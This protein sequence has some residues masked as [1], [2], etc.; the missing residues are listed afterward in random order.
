MVVEFGEQSVSLWFA[1]R[2]I[3]SSCMTKAS[4][5]CPLR[6]R[7]W[8]ET[9]LK[10]GFSSL[11]WVVKNKWTKR[12]FPLWLSVTSRDFIWVLIYLTIS[13]CIIATLG[14]RRHLKYPN[15]APTF[16]EW[17]VSLRN[18]LI[19]DQPFWE[20]C[21]VPQILLLKGTPQRVHSWA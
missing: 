11:Q 16:Q 4:N 8:L 7:K 1:D 3:Q 6:K 18:A 12:Q 20:C 17:L 21:L 13:H 15:Q 9:S 19:R 10:L 14:V 2:G 5:A